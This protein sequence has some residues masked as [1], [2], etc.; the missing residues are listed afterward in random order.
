MTSASPRPL[1]QIFEMHREVWDCD[2]IRP[3]VRE[4]FS[5]VIDCGTK[6]LGAEVFASDVNRSPFLRLPSPS[7]RFAIAP[8]R[9]HTW[10]SFLDNHLLKSFDLILKL[11]AFSL[12]SLWV[13]Q[14]RIDVRRATRRSAGSG[15]CWEAGRHVGHALEDARPNVLNVHV[16][17][18]LQREGS[19]TVVRIWFDRHDGLI[20][21]QRD[22]WHD[23]VLPWEWRR[24]SRTGRRSA[25]V[26]VG[27]HHLSES[28]RRHRAFGAD[29]PAL[30]DP[31]RRQRRQHQRRARTSSR[32]EPPDTGRVVTLYSGSGG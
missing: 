22:R 26:R 2:K 16:H 13:S 18:R 21:D 8:H 28:A 19:R 25:R 12:T 17:Q 32:V 6:A 29:H 5:K 4:A 15:P 1:R 3:S 9:P 23:E 7:I 27:T 24:A 20:A 14:P 11:L 10:R 31:A 30:V